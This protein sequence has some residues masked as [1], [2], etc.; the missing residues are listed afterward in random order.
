[1][2]VGQ[3]FLF[4][5]VDGGGTRC[6]AR[7]VNAGGAILGES[8]AGP[9]N[10]RIGL[11]ESV[12]SVLA[13]TGHCLAQAGAS[14]SDTSD[15]IVACLALAGASEP[16]DAAAAQAAFET[17]FARAQITTDAHAACVGAHRGEDGGMIIVGTGS[18]G[19]AVRGGPFTGV[20]IRVGGWGFPVSDEGSGAWIGWEAVRRTLLAHD[21]RAAWTPLLTEVSQALGSEPHAIVEWTG[22]ARPRDFGRLAPLVLHHA[23]H[24]DLAAREIMRLAAG[25]ID[26]IAARLTEHGATRLALMGGLA[27]GIEPWLANATRRHLVRPAGDALDGALRLAQAGVGPIAEDGVR[28]LAS[29][30]VQKTSAG[31]EGSD[32]VYSSDAGGEGSDPIHSSDPVHSRSAP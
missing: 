16:G 17:H 28:P 21:G 4:L 1:L 24:E 25:H 19:W 9:A 31:G 7:L 27:A 3:K 2:Q 29:T 18:I 8:V 10:I 15:T 14:F 5:G 22:S 12:R 26:A 23:A 6:R 13:A 30:P 32:P 20:S 11:E